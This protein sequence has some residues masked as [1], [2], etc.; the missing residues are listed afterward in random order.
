MS[1][2]EAA[3]VLGLP[4]DT[5]RETVIAAHRTLM[6]RLHPDKGGSDYLAMK[7][8]AARQ[9]MLDALARNS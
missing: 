1:L 5:D 8:N 4:I 7:V 2:S 6:S 3:D 9:V